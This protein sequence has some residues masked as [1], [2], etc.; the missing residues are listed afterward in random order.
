MSQMKTDDSEVFSRSKSPLK[1][2]W[3]IS[4]GFFSVFL[5]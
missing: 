3:E 5:L 2:G 1:I 4:F